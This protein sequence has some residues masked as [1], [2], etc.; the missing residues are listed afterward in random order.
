MATRVSIKEQG[1]EFVVFYGDYTYD[2]HATRAAAEVQAK[3]LEL[4]E[5]FAAEV[6]TA[7]TKLC[8]QA[9]LAGIPRD[10]AVA[11]IQGRAWR[12]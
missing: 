6:E 10:V 3:K 1:S 9:A 11:L 12:L 8:D 2:V 5:A 4:R 7:L